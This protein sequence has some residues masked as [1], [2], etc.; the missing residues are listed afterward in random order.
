MILKAEKSSSETTWD[1]KKAESYLTSI[2]LVMDDCCF[3]NKKHFFPGYGVDSCRNFIEFYLMVKSS[4][5]KQQKKNQCHFTWFL[6]PFLLPYHEHIKIVN[7]ADIE[8]RLN[9]GWNL[10]T[11]LY[12]QKKTINLLQHLDI[13][14]YQLQCHLSID[15]HF[16]INDR[17]VLNQQ[18]F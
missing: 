5:P 1:G 10:H 8:W 9:A 15:F 13:I 18:T 16:N 4:P 12:T 7:G 11:H 6:K 3:C 14:N 17:K 2:C